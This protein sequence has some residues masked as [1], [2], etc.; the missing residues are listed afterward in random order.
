MNFIKKLSPGRFA[1]VRFL[2]AIAF[3]LSVAHANAGVVI[4][5]IFDTQNFNV[6][7]GAGPAA[8]ITGPT[9]T[10]VFGTDSVV[11]TT[12]TVSGLDL[13]AIDP[14][15]TNASFDFTV[16]YT[17]SEVDFTTGTVVPSPVN[18]PPNNSGTNRF[19]SV[20]D[21]DFIG[22]GETLR[23]DV[24]GVSNVTGFSDV[25]RF[26]GFVQVDAE[27]F[28]Q[29]NDAAL[30]VF[31]D[32]TS[33]TVV[34]DNTSFAGVFGATGGAAFVPS[35]SFVFTPTSGTSRIGRTELQF[36]AI[37]EPSSAFAIGLGAIAMLIGRRRYS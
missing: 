19:V 31:G 13:S 35:N 24:L 29:A 6:N 18:N 20:G 12:Y 30:G 15:A 16:Q 33:Q 26:N 37:P 10:G 27:T 22:V 7:G 17:G 9:L 21:D 14:T 36:E 28:Q 25:I 11:T 8:T 34:T 2:T 1:K 3:S 23:I 5:T 32:G 4:D